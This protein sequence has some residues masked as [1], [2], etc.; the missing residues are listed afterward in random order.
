MQEI[1]VNIC[2]VASIFHRPVCDFLDKDSAGPPPP[3]PSRGLGTIHTADTY[4]ETQGYAISPEAPFFQER[5]GDD[6]TRPIYGI[7]FGAQDSI[8]GFPL[9]KPH[10]DAQSLMQ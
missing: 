7:S 1:P 3:P 2:A 5:R 8:Q 10:F 6:R 4:E 9:D